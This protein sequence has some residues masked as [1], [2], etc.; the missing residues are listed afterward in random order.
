MILLLENVMYKLHLIVKN[1]MLEALE[2]RFRDAGG[3][4]LPGRGE[5]LGKVE[6]IDLSGVCAGLAES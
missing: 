4:L 3:I 5:S 2:I 1:D 6:D